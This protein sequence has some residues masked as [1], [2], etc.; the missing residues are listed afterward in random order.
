[1]IA[2]RSGFFTTPEPRLTIEVRIPEMHPKLQAEYDRVSDISG[3]RSPCQRSRTPRSVPIQSPAKR[4]RQNKQHQTIRQAAA[5]LDLKRFAY[6]A[7]GSSDASAA[8]KTT[9]REREKKRAA[10]SGKVTKTKKP[11]ARVG[12]EDR[13]RAKSAFAKAVEHHQRKRAGKA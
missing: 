2:G 3:A 5:A 10:A 12:R 6:N 1:M 9:S 11:R 8:S 4:T 7:S 13:L